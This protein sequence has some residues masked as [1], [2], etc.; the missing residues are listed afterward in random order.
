MI[1]GDDQADM[2]KLQGRWP[3]ERWMV[4]LEEDVVE[5][6]Q[7]SSLSARARI[8]LMRITNHKSQILNRES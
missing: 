1:K 7:V 2:T 4:V 5:V 6:C 8:R 3:K